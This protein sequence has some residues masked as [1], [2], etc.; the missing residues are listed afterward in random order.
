MLLVSFTSCAK[1]EP[2]AP[3]ERVFEMRASAE[4]HSFPVGIESI[5]FIVRNDTDET[6]YT[7]DGNRIE[8]KTGNGWEDVT[9]KN[10]FAVTVLVTIEPGQSK[11]FD[12][13][14]LPEENAWKAGSYRL[15][16]PFRYSIQP[17]LEEGTI[18][19]EFTLTD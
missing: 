15:V 16:K 17:P 1:E 5:D 11:S 12:Y 7:G 18:L 14:F 13:Y 3:K 19:Y 8:M 2:R 9:P 6:I 10:S 4:T